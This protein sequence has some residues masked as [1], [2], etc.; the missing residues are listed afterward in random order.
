M[1]QTKSNE[2]NLDFTVLN[3]PIKFY[4]DLKTNF[5]ATQLS[6]LDETNNIFDFN[7]ILMPIKKDD[8]YGLAVCI[9]FLV[10]LWFFDLLGKKSLNPQ[11]VFNK[12]NFF[13]PLHWKLRLT[14][15]SI[16]KINFVMCS[17]HELYLC[18]LKIATR[19]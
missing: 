12:F 11:R 16:F 2:N 5:L 8:N 3:F 4:S 10:C 7:L 17:V 15:D 18:M 13:I 6:I 14:K 9:V 19:G 1:L